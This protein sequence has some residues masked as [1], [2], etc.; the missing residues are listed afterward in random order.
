MTDNSD[1]KGNSQTCVE[2]RSIDHNVNI[3]CYPIDSTRDDQRDRD[4]DS[5]LSVNDAHVYRTPMFPSLT[6]PTYDNSDVSLLNLP[7]PYIALTEDQTEL[8]TVSIPT[9]E[10]SNEVPKQY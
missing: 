8:Y 1:K 6:Y 10:F 5:L 9:H 7:Q 4:V 2:D 3:D